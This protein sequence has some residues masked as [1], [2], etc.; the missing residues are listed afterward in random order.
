MS[1]GTALPVPYAGAVFRSPIS[2]GNAI[3][4]ATG[5][6]AYPITLDKIAKTDCEYTV[7]EGSIDV[8]D[9]SESDTP[10]TSLMCGRTYQAA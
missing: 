8:T 2:S 9:D 5:G 7:E 10:P 4:L 6:E 1:T 3:S